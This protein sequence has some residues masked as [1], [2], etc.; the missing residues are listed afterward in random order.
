MA[1]Q[2]KKLISKPSFFVVAVFGLMIIFVILFIVLSA[3]AANF[4]NSPDVTSTPT[5]TGTQ[6]I[7]PTPEIL[8]T[9]FEKLTGEYIWTD[10]SMKSLYQNALWNP[11]TTT[12]YEGFTPKTNLTEVRTEDCRDAPYTNSLRTEGGIC[13]VS[14]WIE[15][16]IG[17]KY[18]TLAELIENFGP[19]D[20]NAEA[21][22]F[23]ASTHRDLVINTDGKIQGLSMQVDGG[24][25]VQV[26]RQNTFGCSNH[27]PTGMIFFIS[28]EGEMSLIA[29]EKPA[30]PT[31]NEPFICAD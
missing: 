21:V 16:D 3:L 15:D 1:D 17:H 18:D 28:T 13:Q 2:L 20:T 24:Y 22:S 9:G 25:L 30:P 27:I 7:T 12:R 14:F 8:P 26:T 10:N 19:V 5:I 23:V 6:S 31:T 11:I 29:T 4:G